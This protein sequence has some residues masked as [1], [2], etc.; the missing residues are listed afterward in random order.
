M[1]L[2][3]C[4]RLSQGYGIEPILPYGV[5]LVQD[6]GIYATVFD[7]IKHDSYK[8]TILAWPHVWESSVIRGDKNILNVIG[9]RLVK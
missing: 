1:P 7:A 5:I 3:V 6:D 4:K 8:T 2:L 9:R